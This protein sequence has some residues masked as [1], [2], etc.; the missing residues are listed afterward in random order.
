MI[1]LVELQICRWDGKHMRKEK[2]YMQIWGMG[3]VLVLLFSACSG[4]TPVAMVM[5]TSVP[6]ATLIPATPQQSEKILPT[7]TELTSLLQQV[8]DEE[9]RAT[10]MVIGMVAPGEQVIAGYGSLSE[11]GGAAPDGDSL[12]EIGSI[13]KVFIGTLLADAV[14]R[15]EVHLDDPAGMYLPA[16]V[17]MPDYQ[18]IPITLLDL[19]THTSGLPRELSAEEELT[20]ENWIPAMYGFLS[21][22]QL[23]YAPGKKYAYSNLGMTLLAHI[24]ALRTGMD[25]EQLVSERIFQPLQLTST[26][27]EPPKEW[28]PRLA[29]GH[30]SVLNPVDTYIYTVPDHVYVG[31]IISSAEDMLRFAS[32]AM[33]VDVTPL[34]PAFQDSIRPQRNA[35]GSRIGLAW[36]VAE[37]EYPLISHAGHTSGMH[38]YLGL[39]PDRKIGVIVLANAAIPLDDIGPHLLYPERYTLEKFTPRAVITPIPVDP[40]ILASYAGNYEFEDMTIE[41][42]VEGSDL[43]MI[44]GGQDVLNLIAET[45]R[46]YIVVEYDASISF[47]VD[48]GRVVGLSLDQADASQVFTFWKAEPAQ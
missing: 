2:F 18:G 21:G 29:V 15:G 12:F 9:K 23:T 25:Y 45:E 33:G 47:L 24:L 13:S 36:M 28:L 5:P 8:V 39:D 32:A 20:E 34:L 16:S 4:N 10:G 19:A 48:E 38:A 22:Y 26:G 7:E 30:N 42:A 41:I 43:I 3:V 17:K 6:T 1:F 46:R 44:V 27:F 14:R 37:G 35:I 40:A 31:A 11:P